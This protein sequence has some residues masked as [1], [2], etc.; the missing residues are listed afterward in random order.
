MSA[1]AKPWTP[2]EWSAILFYAQIARNPRPIPVV[3]LTAIGAGR[4]AASCLRELALQTEIFGVP[5][6]GDAK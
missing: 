5:S 4:Y 3:K 6:T 2:E 1:S